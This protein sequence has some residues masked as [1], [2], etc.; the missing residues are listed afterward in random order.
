LKASGEANYDESV[1]QQIDNNAAKLAKAEKKESGESESNGDELDSE[2][3]NALRLAAEEG[4]ISS[5]QL[6]RKLRLGFQRA[7]RII[8]Q[9]YDMGY[10]GEPNGSKPRDVL[11]TLDDYREI[12]MRREDDEE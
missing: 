5:S 2:F 3:Y 6:Q 8:D 9:M 4:K 7:A 12:M 10:I 11:I 1:M